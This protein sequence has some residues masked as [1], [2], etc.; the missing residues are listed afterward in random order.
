MLAPEQKEQTMDKEAI[1]VDCPK[2]GARQG[3]RCVDPAPGGARDEPHAER[4]QAARE[5]R[6]TEVAA[7]EQAERDERFAEERA[8][9]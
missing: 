2:C 9:A 6:A 3:W 7:D 4:V 5:A 8:R 1:T